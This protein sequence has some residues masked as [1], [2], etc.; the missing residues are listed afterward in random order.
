[1]EGPQVSFVYYGPQAGKV[2]LTGEFNQWSREGQA[3]PMV[4]LSASGFFYHTMQL[5][6]PAR[7]E[8]KFIVDGEWRLDPICSNRV[9]N[10]LGDSNSYFI[11]GDF[12]E[13][14]ELEWVDEIRHGR[15]EQFEFSSERLNNARRV[16]V[17][18]PAAYDDRQT[19]HFP[20]LYVHD[21]GE[22]L[23]RAK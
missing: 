16:Y 22:Y 14:P 20:A 12:S 17:Y 15:V 6:E 18:V 11:V 8:Y 3:I 7:L 13:P 5:S 21:G 10:G 9:D 19:R 23:E 1:I 2:D 4:A